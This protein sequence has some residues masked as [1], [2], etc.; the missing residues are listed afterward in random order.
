MQ[1]PVGIS[2]RFSMCTARL[3]LHLGWLLGGLFL[4]WQ[5]TLIVGPPKADLAQQRQHLPR[6]IPHQVLHMATLARALCRLF[7]L[8]PRGT[9]HLLHPSAS[10]AENADHDLLLQT[11]EVSFLERLQALQQ[12][13]HFG[14]GF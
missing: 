3:A 8:S 2:R 7:G 4:C 14:F 1:S 13:A 6:S 12:G 9:E 11:F 10:N 5:A